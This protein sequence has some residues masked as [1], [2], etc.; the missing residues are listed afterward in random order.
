M[1]RQPW[2]N[3]NVRAVD[4][5]SIKNIITQIISGSSLITEVKAQ[6]IY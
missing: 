5:I 6:G 2:K 1:G 4:I 3:L